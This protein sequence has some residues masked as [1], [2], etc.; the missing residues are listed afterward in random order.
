MLS[1]L[2]DINLLEDRFVKGVRLIMPHQD[3][4]MLT[5]FYTS[6]HT[7]KI[8]EEMSSILEKN[9]FKLRRA[10]WEGKGS[11]ACCLNIPKQFA[12]RM[13]L[14]KQSY[15]KVTY[16]NDEHKLVVEKLVDGGQVANK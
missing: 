7:T 3:S 2:V 14:D 6:I 1:S 4:Y 10:H 13:G 12:E 16:M 5:N 8:A 11:I 15:L 9:E